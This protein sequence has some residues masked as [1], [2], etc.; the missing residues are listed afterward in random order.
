MILECE[1]EVIPLLQRK[2]QPWVSYVGYYA[3][4]SVS[5]ELFAICFTNPIWW[6]KKDLGDL[7]RKGVSMTL[8][9]WVVL[10]IRDYSI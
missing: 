10:D 2:M 8:Q 1:V 9:N 4:L 3:L 5:R 7:S 6:K